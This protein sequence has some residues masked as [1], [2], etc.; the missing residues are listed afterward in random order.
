MA[1]NGYGMFNPKPTVATV[2]QG[3]VKLMQPKPLPNP[4]VPP[5]LPSDITRD[6]PDT[7]TTQYG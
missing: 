5:G 3:G 2:T 6:L 1:D 4:G 7:Y